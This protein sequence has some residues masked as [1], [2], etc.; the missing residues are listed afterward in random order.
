MDS[1]FDMDLAIEQGCDEAQKFIDQ[2]RKN[3]Q[4]DM[5]DV[6]LLDA[7]LRQIP[8]P[9]KP[10]RPKGALPLKGLGL[11]V[12][13]PT[14]RSP[15]SPS[16]NS[17]TVAPSIVSPPAVKNGSARD[18]IGQV[19]IVS[20]IPSTNKGILKPGAISP[21]QTP[22]KTRQHITLQL[23]DGIFDTST[24]VIKE[25]KLLQ[26][27]LKDWGMLGAND[28][29]GEFGPRTNDA[30]K[31]FQQKKSLEVDGVVGLNTWAALLKVSS[32]EV[33]IIPRIGSSSN[34][35]LNLA[36]IPS[37]WKPAA[38]KYVPTLVKAFKAQGIHNPYVFAYAC[39]T[40]CHESSWNPKAVNTT[41]AAA[42]SGYPGAGL[43][44]ITWK[45]NYEMATRKTGIDFVNHPEYMFDPEKSLRA[46][47]AFYQEN[48]M[49][50]Y[51]E[52]GDYES[53]AGIYNAGSPGSRS[54]YTR[55]VAHDTPL[56]FPVFLGENHHS[57]SSIISSGSGSTTLPSNVPREGIR[58][59]VLDIAVRE[60]S[61]GRS[62]APGNEIDVL[63]LDPLRPIMVELNHLGASQKDV[64]YNWCAAWVTYICRSAGIKIPDRY[65]NFWAS[66]ALVDSWRDM[67]KR[68][69]AWFQKGTRS[70]KPGDIVCFN[71]DGDTDLDHIG[72]IRGL[73]PG[74]VLTCEGNKNNIEGLFTRNLSVVDGFLDIEILAR[75]L[76]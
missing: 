67:G 45:D 51:I 40:I 34:D 55:K 16:S 20:D 68:T 13:Q 75:E 9:A 22:A 18:A 28:I 61:K 10:D 42:R 6:R 14:L 57:G 39:A 25:V 48:R 36:K 71:W 66:V 47:A 65:K 31:R 58:Q 46:K 54:S 12:V 4:K 27:C 19:P 44:Q 5:S 8:I 2:L 76:T 41:D 56:W 60:A 3:K 35:N 43:A 30:V 21:D 63:V 52:R 73:E 32:S 23:N 64:F 59:R 37:E 11:G 33:E 38:A 50:P 70:P 15:N 29:D 24:E 62:H 1:N 69:G 17:S 7:F 74:A 49:I 53:A 26:Q 72:I